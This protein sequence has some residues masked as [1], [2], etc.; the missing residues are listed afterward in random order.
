[1]IESNKFRLDQDYYDLTKIIYQTLE[2]LL[3]QANKKKL[4]IK[5]VI[6]KEIN[7]SILNSLYGDEKRMQQIIFNLLSNS[8]N[9]T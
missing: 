3:Y 7:L 6:D 2:V 9:L 8:I 1:M 5:V 4:S